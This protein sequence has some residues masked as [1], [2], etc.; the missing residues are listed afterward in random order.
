MKAWS[1]VRYLHKTVDRR[2]EYAVPKSQQNNSSF[3]PRLSIVDK[4]LFHLL[5]MVKIILVLF[6]VSPDIT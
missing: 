5:L 1:Q 3:L 6:S 2:T 4:I